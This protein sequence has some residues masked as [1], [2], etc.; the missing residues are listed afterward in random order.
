MHFRSH[1][2][3]PQ[4]NRVLLESHTRRAKAIGYVELDYD[5]QHVSL[6]AGDTKAKYIGIHMPKNRL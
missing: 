6:L 4:Y 3:N 2:S 5:V 1:P